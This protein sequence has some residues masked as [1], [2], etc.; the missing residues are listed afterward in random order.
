MG[1]TGPVR[2]WFPVQSAARPDL[3]FLSAGGRPEVVQLAQAR[4]TAMVTTPNTALAA[5]EAPGR[6]R[7]P[8]DVEVR[9][10][11]LGTIGAE[12][13]LTCRFKRAPAQF[14]RNSGGSPA[15]RRAV[16]TSLT[17]SELAFCP[18][19]SAN[20]QRARGETSSMIRSTDFAASAL[21][22]RRICEIA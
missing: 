11:G 7:R 2:Y 4:A 15:S 8:I 22:P 12:D 16:E 17:S 1:N 9:P 3:A 5:G 19:S 13:G 20:T 18:P 14:P 6:F 10:H 21:R